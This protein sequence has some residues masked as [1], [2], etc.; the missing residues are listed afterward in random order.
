M[1]IPTNCSREEWAEA[2]KKAFLEPHHAVDQR[3]HRYLYINLANKKDARIGLC[4]IL[5][6]LP[7]AIMSILLLS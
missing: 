1:G 2:L 6:I 7:L 4:F 5:P 3:G